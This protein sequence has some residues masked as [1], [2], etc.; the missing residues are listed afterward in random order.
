VIYKIERDGYK[1]KELDLEISDIIDAFPDNVSYIAAHNFCEHN[2]SLLSTW[3]LLKSGFSVIENH[4]NLNPD[5]CVWIDST[6][7][8]SAK[9]KL[10]LGDALAEYGEFLPLI[11]DDSQYEIFN[12]L[13]LRD[14]KKSD[15]LVFKT[16]DTQCSHLYCQQRLRGLVEKFDLHGVAFSLN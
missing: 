7:L 14:T 5:I 4:E 2:I 15:D 3:P 1:F 9:A 13:T 6:L 11:V 10:H 12:C 16:I 8:L